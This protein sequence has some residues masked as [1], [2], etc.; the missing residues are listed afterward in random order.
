MIQI[1]RPLKRED[2]NADVTMWRICRLL[3]VEY[4][5]APGMS[6]LHAACQ[7]ED[8]IQE[9]ELQLILKIFEDFD[10]ILKY[11]EDPGYSTSGPF[12]F[13]PLSDFLGNPVLAFRNTLLDGRSNI[14][15]DGSSNSLRSA[16]GG[17][18]ES[19]GHTFLAF[20]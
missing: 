20:R 17:V 4:C 11:E 8:G 19:G 2:V 7:K 16:D 1:F 6:W 3:D 13:L 15:H 12:Y 14:F 5:C 10:Y 9:K 18:R